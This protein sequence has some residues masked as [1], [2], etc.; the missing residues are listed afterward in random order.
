M[1]K[2]NIIYSVFIHIPR[3]GGLFLKTSLGIFNLRS[4][5]Q[6]RNK[7]RRGKVY[8]RPHVS[9]GHQD[10]LHLVEQRIVNKEFDRQAFKYTFCRNPF[11]WVVSA[12]FYITTTSAYDS[13]LP[14]STSFLEFTRMLGNI[15]VPNKLEAACGK[16]L[17]FKPQYKRIKGIDLGFIG[18]F[19]NLEE[20]VH[21]VGN[22][23][24][25]EV[26][27]KEPSHVTDHLPFSEYYN[28]ES[29]KNVVKFYKKDFEFFGYSTKLL[30]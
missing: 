27:K 20:D 30:V 2:N 4:P 8:K 22:I 10:Y 14:K 9:F 17:W 28:D 26:F 18:R 7:K 15:K 21:K 6:T 11:D 1:I 23:L 5:R 29:I 16:G 13:L 25:L 12:Y 19:E 3:T 24:G